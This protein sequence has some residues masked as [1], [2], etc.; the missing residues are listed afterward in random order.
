LLSSLECQDSGF[1]GS[2]M[3]SVRR[4]TSGCMAYTCSV[5]N[6]CWLRQNRAR[7][8]LKHSRHRSGCIIA[9]L[10]RTRTPR[11]PRLRRPGDYAGYSRHIGR[12]VLLY[13]QP[14]ASCWFEPG[15]LHGNRSRRWCGLRPHRLTRWIR[16]GP[17]A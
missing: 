11:L 12:D 15:P 7:N 17:P 14:C 4:G 8:L 3:L 9:G 1:L 5:R 16:S 6:E 13:R 2:I 10:H